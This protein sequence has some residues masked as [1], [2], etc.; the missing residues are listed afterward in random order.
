MVS[1]FGRACGKTARALEV[2]GI[3]SSAAALLR[4][5]ALLP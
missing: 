5:G 3:Q 4:I 1:R 2:R